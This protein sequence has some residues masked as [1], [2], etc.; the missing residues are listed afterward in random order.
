MTANGAAPLFVPSSPG[1]SVREASRDILARLADFRELFLPLG[2]DGPVF[3]VRHSADSLYAQEMRTERDELR[4]QDAQLVVM[5][6]ALLDYS[7]WHG[8]THER[9]CPCDDTCQCKG[10]A[11]DDAVNLILSRTEPSHV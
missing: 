3:T 2:F 9:D 7:R 5:R 1:A 10:K 11:V 6:Q 4:A 8:A